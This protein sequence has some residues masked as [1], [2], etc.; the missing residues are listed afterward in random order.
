MTQKNQLRRISA[1]SFCSESYYSE[2]LEG[3]ANNNKT[4]TRRVKVRDLSSAGEKLSAK[5]MKNVKG[6][7][8]DKKDQSGGNVN[9]L[10][11]SSRDANLFS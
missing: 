10:V 1:F 11:A 6:G 2:R 9:L 8:K 5:K 4:K 7:A 3:M